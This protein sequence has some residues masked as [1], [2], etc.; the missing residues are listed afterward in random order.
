MLELAELDRVALSSR[1][2]RGKARELVGVPCLE[3]SKI[4]LK[5]KIAGSGPLA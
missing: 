2:K 1:E 4:A 3:Q 5:F